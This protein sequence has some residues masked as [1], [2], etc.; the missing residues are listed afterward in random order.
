MKGFLSALWR[1]LAGKAEP[2][3]VPAA[4][5]ELPPSTYLT[6]GEEWE[7]GAL[8]QVSGLLES[9]KT[10]LDET[11]KAAFGKGPMMPHYFMMLTRLQSQMVKGALPFAYPKAGTYAYPEAD[12]FFAEHCY[13]PATALVNFARKLENEGN[14]TTALFLA[15]ALHAATRKA[16]P[17]GQ[18]ELA[19]RGYL[20]EDGQTAQQKFFLSAYEAGHSFAPVLRLNRPGGKAPRPASGN[21]PF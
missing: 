10:V 3:Q 2:Q 15:K 1:K 14:G 11:P 5:P 19:G 21:G 6:L 17:A 4:A 7:D 20:Y 18:E 8:L 9:F 12:M 13:M 16:R